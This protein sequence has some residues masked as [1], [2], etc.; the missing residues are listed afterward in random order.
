MANEDKRSDVICCYE[1]CTAIAVD[2]LLWRGENKGSYC[3]RHL[4]N[5][6]ANIMLGVDY[7]R[8]GVRPPCVV[9]DETLNKGDTQRRMDQ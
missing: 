1:G 9:V 6:R 7:S 3:Q 2:E 8:A 5:M 4:A